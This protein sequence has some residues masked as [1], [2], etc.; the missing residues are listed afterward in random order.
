MNNARQF[1]LA[2]ALF[3]AFAAYPALKSSPRNYI[4]VQDWIM[5][6]VGAALVAKW[7]FGLLR[8][9][10]TVLLDCQASDEVQDKIR[11]AI[12][13]DGDSRVTDLHVW[14]IGPG[15]HSAQVTLVAHNPPSPDEYK[16]RIPKSA[17]LVH[18]SVEVHICG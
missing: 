7:S 3:L 17:N 12:E 8:T 11:D 4:P 9:T 1:H 18:I 15:I 13:A 6:L 10:A 16:S 5:G 14:S 2:F